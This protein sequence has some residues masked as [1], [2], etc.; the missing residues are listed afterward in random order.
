MARCKNAKGG[1]SDEDP[2]PSP[3]LTAQEKVKAKKTTIKKQKLIDVETER[4]AVVQP[5]LSKWRERW[6]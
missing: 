5:L 4:A 1:L 3:C 6:S 2:R